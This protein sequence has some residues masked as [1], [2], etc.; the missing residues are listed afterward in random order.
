M[1]TSHLVVKTLI[2]RSA[3]IGSERVV[4][5]PSQGRVPA[6][7]RTV[8]NPMEECRVIRGRTRRVRSKRAA[9]ERLRYVRLRGTA[10]APRVWLAGRSAQDVIAR[11]SN[12]SGAMESPHLPHAPCDATAPDSSKTIPAYAHSLSLSKPGTTMVTASGILKM[13]KIA[14]MYTGYPRLVTTWVT[15]GPL[16]TPV[17]PCV[18][19][20]TPPRN[21]SSAMRD[22][23]A[24]Y[25]IV[26]AFNSNPPFACGGEPDS[27]SVKPNACGHQSMSSRSTAKE[28]VRN[29]D[30]VHSW[31]PGLPSRSDNKI[32]EAKRRIARAEFLAKCATASTVQ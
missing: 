2:C 26:L 16:T 4:G 19:S 13:P 8:Q 27:G 6:C 14:R 10:L 12:D 15:N 22:V 7:G 18:R 1:G 29:C 17:R 5:H 11:Q 20:T 9:L 31:E 21:V 23:V 25:N 28:L 32:E 3:L 30:A 24:Q